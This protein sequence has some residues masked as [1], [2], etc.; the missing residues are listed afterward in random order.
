MLL[1]W[2][3]TK[4]SLEVYDGDDIDKLKLLATLV[5]LPFYS[6]L[7][8]FSILFFTQDKDVWYVVKC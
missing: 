7:V 5:S 6:A 8:E 1:C 3:N 2:L 4:L